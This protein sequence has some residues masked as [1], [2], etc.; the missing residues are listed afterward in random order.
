MNVKAWFHSPMF[1]LNIVMMSSLAFLVYGFRPPAGVIEVLQLPVA[2]LQV[3]FIIAV[4]L[5]VGARGFIAP[6]SN[7]QRGLIGSLI[8]Y[9]IIVSVTS[10]IPSAHSLV[11]SWV[12][13]ALF[14]VA[15][16]AFFQNVGTDKSE[17]IWPVLG[18]TAGI[19]VCAFLVAWIV[20]P[21]NIARMSIP[22]FGNVRHLGY[23]LAPVAAVM[24]LQFVTGRDR[25]PI[26]LLCFS[27][28]AFYLIYTGSRGGIAALLAGLTITA[29][30]LAWRGQAVHR[31]RI[32][33]LIVATAFLII[34]SE[35]LPSLPWPPLVSRWI[36]DIGQDELEI[37]QG[38]GAIWA[39]AA[40]A[41]KQSPAFGYGPILLSEVPTYE[42]S[43]AY[44][45]PHNIGLQ[46]L[47]HW[48]MVGSVILAATACSFAANILNA[49]HRQPGQVL[50]PLAGL[51]TVCIHALVDGGLFYP[52]STL[53]AVTFFALLS[54]AENQNR[55]AVAG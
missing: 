10:P 9:I 17:S 48:G 3:Y 42:I 24:A 18:F 27:L 52:F 7:L 20:W 30:Y 4:L 49:L 41:I 53:L 6:L 34:I 13:H 43:K 32:A 50:L 44:Y 36:F 35:V 25:A 19:H 40:S 47:L 8:A 29:V 28:A 2:G 11:V 37:I 16:L 21:E 31:A 12:L 33:A 22:A 1:R 51:A 38:R 55:P 23:L 26:W 15:L 5:Q 54:S 39:L 14:F 45:Q 46:L